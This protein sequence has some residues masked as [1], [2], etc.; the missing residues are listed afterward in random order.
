MNKDP[1]P[2]FESQESGIEQNGV[3]NLGIHHSPSLISTYCNTIFF[4]LL[5][6]IHDAMGNT[7]QWSYFI[8]MVI[9]GAFFVMNLIL[10]V[11]SG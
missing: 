4:L 10:G 1:F 3:Q 7:W 8:S 5:L 2:G 6:Q 11:L 9:I